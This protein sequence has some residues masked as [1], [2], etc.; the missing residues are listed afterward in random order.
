ML[1][2]CAFEATETL[3]QYTKGFDDCLLMISFA[4]VNLQF[5]HR[6]VDSFV[7]VILKL[8]VHM[9]IFLAFKAM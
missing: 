8:L 9:H 4:A 7:D 1:A 6:C 2:E 3:V 5:R